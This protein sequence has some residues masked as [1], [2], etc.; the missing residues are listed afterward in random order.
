MVVSGALGFRGQLK[1]APPA[2]RRVIQMYGTCIPQD[3][4][5]KTM[6]QI[7]TASVQF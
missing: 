3:V 2:F 4:S 6:L 7:L 1:Q 5:T